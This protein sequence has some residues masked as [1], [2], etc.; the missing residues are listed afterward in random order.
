M[1]VRFKE[2]VDSDYYYKEKEEKNNN[3]K[4]FKVKKYF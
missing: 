3:Y 2:N 1:I 4:L